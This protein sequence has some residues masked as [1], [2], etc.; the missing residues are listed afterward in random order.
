MLFISNHRIQFSEKQ[1]DCR[2]YDKKFNVAICALSNSHRWKAVRLSLMWHEN[3]MYIPRLHDC[4]IIDFRL[5]AGVDALHV[6]VDALHVEVDEKLCRLS[7]SLWIRSYAG[8]CRLQQAA[9]RMQQVAYRL[10]AACI[11]SYAGGCRLQQAAC[12]MQ[13][14][15]CRLHAGCMQPACSLHASLV[16]HLHNTASSTCQKAQTWPQFNCHALDNNGWV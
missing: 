14:A 2:D 11:R 13:Q 5:H 12:R 7:R 3:G 6:G 8:G 9:C 1:F 10:H 4:Y 16:G 15:A